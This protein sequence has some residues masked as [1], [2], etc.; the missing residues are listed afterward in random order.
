[1]I[2]GNN[3]VNA[4]YN[5]ASINNG[6]HEQNIYFNNVTYGYFIDGKITNRTTGPDEHYVILG[7]EN[8]QS[9]TILYEDERENNQIVAVV[10][11]EATLDNPF[12]YVNSTTDRTDI[13]GNIT[14]TINSTQNPN[15]TFAPRYYIMYAMHNEDNYYTFDTAFDLFEVIPITDLVLKKDGIVEGELVHG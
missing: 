5:A 8:S 11:A 12:I 13:Y 7:A 4:I 15:G 14:Y 10:V 6:T 3:I 1:M 2:G 9:G